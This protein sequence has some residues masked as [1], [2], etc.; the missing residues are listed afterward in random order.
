MEKAKQVLRFALSS[1]ASFVVD[2]GAYYLLHLLLKGTLGA[3]AELVCNVAARVLSSFFNFNVNRRLVFGQ[4]GSYG[5]A[6]LRYYM[7]A[8]PQLA[9]STLL[10]TLFTRLLGAQSAAAS[11]AVKVAVDAL[12]FIISFF[13]QKYWVFRKKES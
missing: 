12:L 8:V 1:G 7:L 6:L 4:S 3:S 10:L 11:T 13:I 2:V 9:A 5:G